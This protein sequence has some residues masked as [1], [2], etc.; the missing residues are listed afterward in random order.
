[1]MEERKISDFIA[2][3]A[4]RFGFDKINK[5]TQSLF[6]KFLRDFYDIHIVI[7]KQV[8]TNNYVIDAITHESDEY[9][10]HDGTYA[11]YEDALEDAFVFIKNKIFD[12]IYTVKDLINKLHEM[13]ECLPVI[14]YKDYKKEYFKIEDIHVVEEDDDKNYKYCSIDIKIP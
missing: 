5:P 1:M 10:S 4:V 7:W 3:F 8:I 2:E 12:D 13:D 6:Q 11:S 9:Q 14:L